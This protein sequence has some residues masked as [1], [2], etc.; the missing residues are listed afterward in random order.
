MYSIVDGMHKLAVELGV[1]FDFNTNAT[2]IAVS[3]T[4]LDVYKRQVSYCF[5]QKVNI[6]NWACSSF[7][8]CCA[9]KVCGYGMLGQIFH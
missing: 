4:H 3:Y 6:M 1:Q 8:T 9:E 5:F 7:I 2:R